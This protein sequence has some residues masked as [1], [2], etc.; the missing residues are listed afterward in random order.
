MTTDPYETRYHRAPCGLLTTTTEGIVVEAND[1]LLAWL[2]RTKS[3]VR[4]VSLASLLDP[5]SRIFLETRHSQVLLLQGRAEQVALTMVATDGTAIPILMNSAVVDTGETPLVHSAVFNATE[6]LAYEQD[7]L[8][9]RRSAE[10][11]GQRLQI[12]HDI[13]TAFG[14]ST[15]DVEVGDAVVRVAREAFAATA[16]SVLLIDDDGV[17]Q[18]VSGTNPL[19]GV[20]A[21]IPSIRATDREIVITADDADVTFPELAAG[22]R[23]ARLEA[24]SVT[25]LSAEDRTIGLLVCFFG[26]TRE[27]D[28]GFL[29]LQ[30]AL[31]RQAAQ[32][33]VRVRLQRDLEHMARYDQLTGIA[34]RSSITETLEA[35]LDAAA[36]AGEPLTVIFV[37]V[38]DFKSVNDAFGHATGDEVLRTLAERFRDGVRTGD[39]V[40]RIGG[41]EFVAICPAADTVAAT[42]IAQRIL[43]LAREPIATA[44]GALE[45]S[46]SVG[47]SVYSPDAGSPPT[48]DALLNRA[49]DAMYSSKAAGKD[50]ALVR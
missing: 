36:Q 37:D 17:L 44:H 26:R 30:Q 46:I 25:P 15:S 50:Q 14:V 19:W 3:D 4:G 23:D 43:Q 18:P 34:N 13:S 12:M 38:D 10:L 20:V 1:T 5:S 24:M 2:G 41:D 39:S 11:S 45:L 40:G 35:S 16:A 49:D 29:E 27:F 33:L 47:A 22:L 9:A 28:R 21:P 42:T 32:T 48:A 7:L 8:R 6:R 31:G